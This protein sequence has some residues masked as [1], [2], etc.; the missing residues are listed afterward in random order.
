[1][2]ESVAPAQRTTSVRMLDA[3]V[4]GAGFAG[5]YALHRLRRQGLSVQVYEQGEDVGGTWY[6]NRYPGA[7]VDFEGTDYSYSFDPQLEQEWEWTERYPA[8][9]EILRYL[10]HVADRYDLRRDIAFGTRVESAAWDDT[11]QRWSVT[12]SH[13]EQVSAQFVVLATG[14]LSAAKVPDIPGVADFEGAVHHTARWPHEGVDLTGLRVA[15]VGTGSSGIQAI[16]VIARQ[17]VEVTVFQRTANFSLPAHNGPVD[18]ERL[19]SLRER[20]REHRQAAR[21]STFGIPGPAPQLSALEVDDDTRAST[22]ERGWGQGALLG[23]LLAF[24]DLIFSKEANDTAAEF[25]RSKIRTIVHDPAVAETLCPRDYPIGTKRVCLDTGYYETFNLP[26]VRLV[27]LRRTPI[28]RVTASGIRTST[29]DHEFDV[30]VFATGFD[31]MT[32]AVTAIDI[33]GRDGL[34]VRDKWAAGPQTYLGLQIAGFPNLFTITGPGSPSVLSNMTVSIEQ[35]VEWVADCIAAMRDRG[36]AAVE[37][38]REAEQAWGEHVQEVAAMTLFP[39]AASWYTGANVPGKPR[40]FLPYL[41]GVGPYR[42]LC[43][44]VAADGYEG[45]VLTPRP[46]GLAR[47]DA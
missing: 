37:P 28:E 43:D 11:V 8:Q 14:C 25:V 38:S 4:V 42:Q 22:Y 18:R 45:F 35:H 3:V 46:A 17:A 27:D 31:A 33:R 16:P 30:I 29:E 12:T 15:V 2:I 9:P 10:Q 26:H 41:G 7:R 20:Y 24:N 39:R 36:V 47:A 44:Q 32:G 1:M 5:L 34:T 23:L 21:E 19:A 13:G 6:W 40:V